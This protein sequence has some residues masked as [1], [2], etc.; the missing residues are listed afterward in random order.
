MIHVLLFIGEDGIGRIAYD[1]GTGKIE[2]TLFSGMVHALNRFLTEIFGKKQW[3]REVEIAPYAL[4]LVETLRGLWVCVHDS[5]DNSDLVYY[6]V[7]TAVKLLEKNCDFSQALKTPHL[8]IDENTKKLL[9][10]ILSPEGV[11]RGFTRL[12][13]QKIRQQLTNRSNLNIVVHNVYLLSMERGIIASWEPGKKPDVKI[14]QAC[15]N[16]LKALPNAPGVVLSLSSKGKKSVEEWRLKRIGSSSLFIFVRVS[17]G[18]GARGLFELVFNNM[19][20]SLE[21]IATS[22]PLV[23]DFTPEQYDLP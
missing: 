22:S 5:T 23:E 1:D 21:Q 10:K 2:Y 20:A 8:P 14:R 17:V 18:E 9:L 6:K 11:P 15:F 4:T 7:S 19:V 3:Y 12:L 16:M 13:D